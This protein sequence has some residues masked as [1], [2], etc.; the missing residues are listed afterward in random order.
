ML[1]SEIEDIEGETIPIEDV[2]KATDI[3]LRF[4]LEKTFTD[5]FVDVKDKMSSIFK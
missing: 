3:D 1:G 4:I 2:K 5:L